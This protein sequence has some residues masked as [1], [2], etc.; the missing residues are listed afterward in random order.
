MSTKRKIE[1]PPVDANKRVA[2]P[3]AKGDPAS[4]LELSSQPSVE[5][6]STQRTEQSEQSEPSPDD[7]HSAPPA[8]GSPHTSEILQTLPES[9]QHV[10][11][12]A[13]DSQTPHYEPLHDNQSHARHDPAARRV[14]YSE[15][16]TAPQ[17]GLPEHATQHEPHTLPHSNHLKAYANDRRAP[18]RNDP[19]VLQ[20]VLEMRMYCSFREAGTIVGKKGETITRLR[21]K[22]EVSI[23]LSDNIQAL[24]ERIVTVRGRSENVAK[25][26]GLITRVLLEEPEDEPALATSQQYDFKLLVPNAIIGYVIGK[27]GMRFREIEEKLAAKLKAAE[28]PLTDSTDR[29]L[30]ISGVADAI[31]IATYYVSQVL[32]LF[33]DVLNKNKVVLY[34]PKWYR[35]VEQ[36]LQGLS[37]QIQTPGTDSHGIPHALGHMNHMPMPMPMNQMPMPV[38]QGM[39]GMMD[40]SH[41]RMNSMAHMGQMH[42]PMGPVP[43]KEYPGMYQP[44][45][46]QYGAMGG[47]PPQAMG[48]AM[49][50]Q[51][52]APQ[53][54]MG[55]MPQAVKDENGNLIFGNIITSQPIL[56]QNGRYLQEVFVS[57]AHIGNVIGKG[58]NNIKQIRINSGC[59]YIKIEQEPQLEVCPITPPNMRRLTLIGPFPSVQLALYLINNRIEQDEIRNSARNKRA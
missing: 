37:L 42:M 36:H 50:Q 28:Q 25:A 6:P 4:D 2:L 12:Q 59:P 30:Q 52:M 47:M 9:L 15:P 24:P 23:Q 21:V 29:V 56:Q 51:P 41:A 17:H 49:P 38:N 1:D 54:Q 10:L 34:D 16:Q 53:H 19:D 3:E 57:H 33:A 35:P 31:H 40:P 55:P 58:G 11:P 32:I 22:A 39:M 13:P 14:S 46:P 8:K 5:P 20:Q 18:E 26:F 27:L 44:S 48:Q 45:R 43:G 7:A